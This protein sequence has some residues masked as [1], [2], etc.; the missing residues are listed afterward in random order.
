VIEVS[1]ICLRKISK[2]K[3]ENSSMAVTKYFQPQYDSFGKGP[4]TFVCISKNTS[5]NLASTGF[6]TWCLDFDRAHGLHVKVDGQ[7]GIRFLSS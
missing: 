6:G 3:R 2:Q 4:Q 1:D 5:I 7:S